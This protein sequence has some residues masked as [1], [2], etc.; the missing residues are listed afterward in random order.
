MGPS[1]AAWVRIT[2]SHV[3]K[4]NGGPTLFSA[5]DLLGV[6]HAK[7]TWAFYLARSSTAC[8]SHSSQVFRKCLKLIS[9][10]TTWIEVLSFTPFLSCLFFHYTSQN[11]AAAAAEPLW[12]QAPPGSQRRPFISQRSNTPGVP[13]KS[14][15]R[16]RERKKSCSRRGTRDARPRW[17]LLRRLFST[18]ARG[19]AQA[20]R[21]CQKWVLVDPEGCLLFPTSCNDQIL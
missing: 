19:P 2:A 5:L 14:N 3:C 18:T 7:K 1:G 16:R 20:R 15:K 6:K 17:T 13:L 21:R 12:H 8:P 4:Y 11:A 9:P 10:S